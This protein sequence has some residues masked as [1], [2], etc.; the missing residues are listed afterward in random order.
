MLREER[1]NVCYGISDKRGK[2]AKIMGTSIY[3]LLKNTESPVTIHILHDETLNE[4]NVKNLK[5]V[6]SKFRQKVCFYDVSE[7]WK[8]VWQEVAEAIA[9][10]GEIRFTLGTFFRLLIGELLEKESRA[11]YLDADTIV[12]LDI[13]ELWEREIPDSGLAAVS[14]IVMQGMVT[15][16]V[17]RG[18][19]EREHYF[20]AGVLL[21]DLDRFRSIDHFVQRS[22]DILAEYQP[23]AFDQ[24]ILN[25]FF[26][27]SNV[28]PERFNCF[29]WRGK[30]GGGV[31]RGYIYHYVD[32]VI[33][34]D[35]EDEFNRLYFYYFT[36]TPWCNERFLGNLMKE[37]EKLNEEYLNFANI[38]AGRRRIVIGLASW[39]AAITG[40]FALREEDI[41]IP[42]EKMD[43]FNVNFSKRKDIFLIF[44]TRNDYESIRERLVSFGLEENVNFV[45]MLALLGVSNKKNREYKLFFEG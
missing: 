17:V 18:L 3:S 9:V 15:L 4:E 5:K 24:D 43:E 35:M 11:I 38:C 21:M 16:S 42:L 33:G 26:P 1:I 29:V 40:R 22:V 31:K 2:Y 10:F 34:L 41:Y 45:N 13:R 20:N 27:L 6:I 37:Q 7:K 36:R 44:L 8:H 23:E 14:D 32:N 25:H 12:N 19:V 39:Q 28:L 30:K